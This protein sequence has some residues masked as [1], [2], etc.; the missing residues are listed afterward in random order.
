M[1]EDQ[2]ENEEEKSEESVGLR[3]S[4]RIKF[5]IKRLMNEQTLFQEAQGPRRNGKCMKTEKC[6]LEEEFRQRINT[7]YFDSDGRCQS[8]KR[9]TKRFDQDALSFNTLKWENTVHAMRSSSSG[10]KQFIKVNYDNETIEEMR[11]DCFS[12]KLRKSDPDQPGF[13]QAM[14]GEE[15]K[16]YWEACKDEYDTLENKMKAW[17][18]VDREDTMHVLP[19]TWALRKKRR[20]DGSVK[21]YK[22]RF[23]VRGDK[24]IDQVDFFADQLY[25]PVC[26]WSTIRLMLVLS[27][28]L[29]LVTVQVDYTSA[30]VQAPI[31]DEVYV[32]MPEG[33]R[34]PGKVLKLLKILYGLKQASRNFF[35]HLQGKLEGA[36]LR[37]CTDLDPC[38]FI[39]DKVIAV[40]YV[41]DTLFFSPK[42]EYIEDIMKRLREGG[43]LEMDKE[44][45]VAGFLGV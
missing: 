7:G 45:D 23:C 27:I 10:I 28:V 11:P 2:L 22:S 31:E 44:D 1:E 21:K 38:L 16:E 12:A 41:D 40:N 13:T 29:N 15:W 34:K 36:G 19:G 30:F 26:S 4:T 35:E 25:S 32:E 5:P 20:P 14:N 39:S 33:F 24:Q 3:R 9:K 6:I 8:S 43:G 42:M 17:E 18:V 37:Q